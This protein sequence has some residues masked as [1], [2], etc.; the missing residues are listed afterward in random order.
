M[1]QIKVD[2]FL[3]FKFV[4]GPEFSP[5]GTMAAFMVQ[6]ADLKENMYKGDIYL[7]E[8]ET[9]KVRRLTGQGDAKGFI[10]TKDGKLI[11]SAKRT[12]EE[13]ENKD[14]AVFYEIDPNGGEA[15]KAFEIP[16]MAGRIQAIDEDLFLVNATQN[17][18]QPLKDRAY[19]IIEE[20]PFWFNGRGFTQGLRGR[21]YTFRRSTGEL[22]AITGETFDAMGGK[23]K[24]GKVIFRGAPWVKGRKYDASGIYV[25]DIASKETKCLIEP[26]TCYGYAVD[27]WTEGK[28]IYGTAPEGA[29]PG[30]SNNEWFT[31]DI[32]TG[33][34][35][36]LT[37]YDYS[38]GS[39][40]GSDARLGGGRSSK[41]VGDK[42]YFVTTVNDGSYLRYMTLDGEVSELLTPDGSLDSFD[43]TADHL[44][45]CGLYGKKLNELYL[46]GEQV[47]H[48]NDKFAE[49]YDIR[50]PEYHE[51]INSDGISI[52]GFAMKPR[53]YEEAVSKAAEEG[54]KA[55]FPAILHIHGGPCT[56]FGNVYHHEMQMWANAGFYVIFCNPRGSDGRGS[57]FE[58]ICNKY[59]TIDYEDIMAFTDEMLKKYPDIDPER[60]GVTGGSYG[61]FMTNWIIGHTDRFKAACSQRSIADW[62]IFEHTSDIGY[63]FTKYHQG[64]RTRENKEQLWEHSPLKYADKCVTPTLF[65]HS[66]KDQRCWMAEG[67]AMFTA[68]QMNGCDSRLAL[69][70]DET[71]E[72]S[73]SGKPK[74][75]I[76]RMEEILNWMKKYLMAE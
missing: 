11:F 6:W 68:L 58:D 21:L 40:V 19:E 20:T 31:L 39:S 24:D 66:D 9:K 4:S 74:N 76:S 29:N 30:M 61:G 18:G 8:V 49:E 44:L 42:Y 25:Y 10:W 1:Q 15:V 54:T 41:L 13:K 60:V 32:E 17:N 52:H 16:L 67:I 53:G 27:F 71:H 23:E 3:E 38:M 72:L 57:A 34:S 33:E 5:D 62:T 26:N 2:T 51:F 45:T 70:H 50:E 46:D 65:I 36:K 48:F 75:R 12:K 73:R 28:L 59:G 63:S 69:F 47:T 14:N 64:A 43:M 35:N 37:F 22:T 7:L 56:V 55:S